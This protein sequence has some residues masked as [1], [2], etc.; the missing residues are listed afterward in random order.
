LEHISWDEWFEKF[1]RADL[2][3][4]YQEHTASGEDSTFV[5]LVRR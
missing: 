4:P 2:A 5:E 1:D 3:F